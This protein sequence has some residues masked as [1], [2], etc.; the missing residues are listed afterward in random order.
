MP[1]RRGRREKENAQLR[2][3]CAMPPKDPHNA[4]GSLPT[5]HSSTECEQPRTTF[6]N[7]PTQNPSFKR[8]L[9]TGGECP[10]AEVAERKKTRSSGTYVRCPLKTRTTRPDLCLHYTHQRNVNNPGPHLKIGQP[11][12]LVS[13]VFWLPEAS[14]HPQRSQRE[15]KRAAPEQI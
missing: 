4:A 13:N 9:A 7:R 11:R 5:L 3:V 8:L 2:N 12:I 10:S 6:K 14:A 15:R 1:I